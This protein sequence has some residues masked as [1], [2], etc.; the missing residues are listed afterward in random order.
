MDV[1]TSAP[2]VA[3]LAAIAAAAGFVLVA[4]FQF[5]L[6]F[7][8][9]RGRGASGGAHNFLPKRLRIASSVGAVIL[10]LGALLVLGRAGYWGSA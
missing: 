6:A 1:S 7:R 9:P 8:A 3:R 4:G 10:V 5:A 2:F